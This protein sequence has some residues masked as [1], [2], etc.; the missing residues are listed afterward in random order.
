MY[1][2]TVGRYIGR[3]SVDYRSTIGQLSVDY[4]PIVGRLSTDSRPVDRYSDRQWTDKCA[5]I[6]RCIGRQS[7]DILVHYRS[8]IGQ[9]SVDYRPIVGRLSTDSRPI[10]VYISGDAL[11]DYRSI[12]RSTIGRLSVDY[13][14][15]VG[16]RSVGCRSTVG[17]LSVNSQPIVDRYIGRL[18][19]YMSTEATYST[20]DPCV[21]DFSHHHDVLHLV[22]V[23]KSSN[24]K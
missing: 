19:A 11:V 21:L 18:S 13:R 7:V 22:A 6:G 17:R 3:L 4:R 9:L 16:R 10:N 15:T 12:Y 24:E 23:W 1:R 20:H 2:P 8:T 5:Y 14:S